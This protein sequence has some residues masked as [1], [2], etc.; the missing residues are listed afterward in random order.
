MLRGRVKCI[1]SDLQPLELLSLRLILNVFLSFSH[2]PVLFFFPVA[3]AS[4]YSM[5]RNQVR[6]NRGLPLAKV[7]YSLTPRVL[8]T[9]IVLTKPA[10][11]WREMLRGCVSLSLSLSG[12]LN[13][14]RSSSYV[15]MIFVCALIQGLAVAV[16]AFLVSLS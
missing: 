13:E 4:L 5:V 10:K 7:V 1:S 16:C 15:L 9:P 8:I 12:S 2:P 6:R 3:A 11:K 14:S